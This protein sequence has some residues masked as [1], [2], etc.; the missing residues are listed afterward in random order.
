MNSDRARI[1]FGVGPDGYGIISESGNTD[2]KYKTPLIEFCK[3]FSW[4]P[5][6]LDH[7]EHKSMA[8]VPC[9]ESTWICIIE[10]GNRDIYNRKLSVLVNAT[11][12]RG[13][14]ARLQKA[15]WKIST[16]EGAELNSVDLEQ[17]DLEPTILTDLAMVNYSGKTGE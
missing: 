9:G 11:L 4:R 16:T 17:L 6:K 13:S 1:V 15:I 10:E 3:S 8:I 12:I 2:S 14:S 5:E 7:P